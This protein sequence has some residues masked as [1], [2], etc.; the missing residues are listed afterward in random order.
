MPPDALIIV[1]GCPSEKRADT[2]E[3]LWQATRTQGEMHDHT[4]CITFKSTE[5]VTAGLGIGGNA[6]GNLFSIEFA[7]TEFVLAFW[8]GIVKTL[9]RSCP[10]ALIRILSSDI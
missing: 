1:K 4:L 7:P 6:D 10:N 2:V 9:S 3:I 8:T 5:P